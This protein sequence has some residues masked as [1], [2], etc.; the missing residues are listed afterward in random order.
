M[1]PSLKF[2][3]SPEPTTAQVHHTQPAWKRRCS[4]P[5][6]WTRAQFSQPFPFGPTWVS[7]LEAF[8]NTWTGGDSNR[9]ERPRTRPE[10]QGRGLYSEVPPW[11]SVTD[12]TLRGGKFRG[13]YV[14]L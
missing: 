2:L 10:G 1:A 13:R 9:R 3:D 12:V 5:F 6:E 8:L 4:T 14:S 7:G 11:A